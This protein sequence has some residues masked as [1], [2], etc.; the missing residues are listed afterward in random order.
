MGRNVTS[1]ECQRFNE[2]GGKRTL[3]VARPALT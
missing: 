1:V 3:L 2:S